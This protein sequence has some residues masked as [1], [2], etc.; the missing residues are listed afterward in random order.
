MT[1]RTVEKLAR[2]LAFEAQGTNYTLFKEHNERHFNRA[3]EL[4]RKLQQAGV[5]VI[6]VSEYF[7]K[8][9]QNRINFVRVD[10][11]VVYDKSNN[12]SF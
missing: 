7:P 9:Q 6:C 10:W 11:Q 8:I 1:K 5:E 4:V 3:M 2:E 12:M